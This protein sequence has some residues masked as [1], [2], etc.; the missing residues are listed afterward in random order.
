MPHDSPR[1]ETSRPARGTHRF[2][3]ARWFAHLRNTSGTGRRLFPL[4]TLKAIRAAIADGEGRH[5]A[6]I[7][8]IVEPG[9]PLALVWQGMTSR[10]RARD[11]FA[12]YRVWDTAENCGVLIYVNLADRKVE[13][14][15]DRGVGSVLSAAEWQAIC[16]AMT[17]GFAR[18][19]FHD[20]TLTGLA[21]LNDLLA[22]RFPSHGAGGQELS[23]RPLIL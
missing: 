6:E 8:L 20:S 5:R 13:I 3:I 19:N 4:A 12:R 9:M 2:R 23:D 1:S 11:V 15:A 14:V 16:H 10:E 17:H 21:Q 18:G 7:R 22:Q